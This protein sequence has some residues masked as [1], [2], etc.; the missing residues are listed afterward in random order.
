MPED[1]ADVAATEEEVE[2]EVLG[3]G[4]EEPSQVA[5]AGPGIVYGL[6]PLSGRPELP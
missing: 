5:T 4:L 6:P 3:L 2:A 1:A